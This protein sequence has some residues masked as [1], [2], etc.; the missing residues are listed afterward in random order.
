LKIEISYSQYTADKGKPWLVKAAGISTSVKT[1]I[2]S[3]VS[4]HGM[5][6]PNAIGTENGKIKAWIECEGEIDYNVEQSV[7]V[8]KGNHVETQKGN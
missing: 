5:Y 4:A 3:N 8:V 7:I 6:N 1:L 2:L